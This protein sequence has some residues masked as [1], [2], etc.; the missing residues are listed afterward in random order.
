MLPTASNLGDLQM[1]Q[2]LYQ[3]EISL[4]RVPPL[5]QGKPLRA[6]QAQLTLI[7]A[8]ANVHLTAFGKGRAV[9]PTRHH[10]HDCLLRSGGKRGFYQ[11]S[12]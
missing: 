9:T 3:A 7:V 10:L 4:E 2:S 11:T 8:P 1:R 6:A 12:F 5:V